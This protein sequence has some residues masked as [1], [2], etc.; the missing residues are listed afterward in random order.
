MSRKTQKNWTRIGQLMYEASNGKLESKAERIMEKLMKRAKEISR[1]YFTY[2][3]GLREPWIPVLYFADPRELFSNTPKR[4][5]QDFATI[6]E[7]EVPAHEIIPSLL[8]LTQK[9]PP[10]KDEEK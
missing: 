7:I 8:S 2:Q 4:V 3:R 9:F 10:P 5:Q 1:V 6:H